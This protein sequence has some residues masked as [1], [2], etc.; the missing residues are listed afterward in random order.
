[1]CA[2]IYRPTRP[3]VVAEF[4]DS[5]LLKVFGQAGAGL[6]VAP[7]AIEREV[8]RQYGVR[9]VGR[10][11]E[12]RESFYAITAERRITHPAL[13]RLAEVAKTRLFA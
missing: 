11:D 3:S 1:M 4:E 2:D 13:V 6:F 9:V 5:A 8:R 7:T 10:I 12:V